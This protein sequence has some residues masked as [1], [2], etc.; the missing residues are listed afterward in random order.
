LVW[1]LEPLPGV[2]TKYICIAT[3]LNA[4]TEDNQEMLRQFQGDYLNVLKATFANQSN[5][6]CLRMLCVG[7]LHNVLSCM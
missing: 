7:V 2:L 4:L 1:I 5:N 6:M 3:L